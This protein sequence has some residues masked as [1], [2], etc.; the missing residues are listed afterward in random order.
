[1]SLAI[2][3]HPSNRRRPSLSL[4]ESAGVRACAARMC[5]GPEDIRAFASS[6]PGVNGAEVQADATFRRRWTGP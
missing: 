6:G 5:A 4:R 2:L 3:T 1:M